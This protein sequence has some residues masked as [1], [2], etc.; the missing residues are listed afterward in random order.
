[1]VGACKSHRMKHVKNTHQKELSSESSPSARPR[2]KQPIPLTYRGWVQSTA[3]INCPYLVF[4]LPILVFSQIPGFWERPCKTCRHRTGACRHRSNGRRP[5]SPFTGFVAVLQF[6]KL[7]SSIR[8]DC[9]LGNAAVELFLAPFLPALVS[10]CSS[11]T[12]NSC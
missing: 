6:L 2:H 12:I 8:N 10:A 11:T 5:S 4:P 9:I 1:M 7:L 3:N